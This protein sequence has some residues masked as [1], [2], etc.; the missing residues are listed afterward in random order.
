MRVV[1]V[2]R[3][4]LLVVRGRGRGRIRRLGTSCSFDDPLARCDQSKVDCMRTNAAPS[5]AH[6][7]LPPYA[8]LFS[9]A[10]DSLNLA[11]ASTTSSS[12]TVS[13]FLA[14]CPA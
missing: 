5:P 13:S 9:N 10:L 8:N 14:F 11:K 12:L 7:L 3:V 6:T 2:G 4:P 1:G